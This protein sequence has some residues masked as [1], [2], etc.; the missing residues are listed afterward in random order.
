MANI[1]INKGSISE[2]IK[3]FQR[4]IQKIYQQELSQLILYGSQA[5]GDAKPG[6]DI[7]ILVIL[8]HGNNDQRKYQQV[9][10]LI[11]DLCLE[12][13]VLI[14]CVYVSENQFLTEKSPLL[15]NIHRE[16]IKL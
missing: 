6:S 4:E 10:N 16:G 8:K 12:Y 1:T 7:D 2:I 14:S 3:K 15:I 9:I 5:R 13:E 11:S